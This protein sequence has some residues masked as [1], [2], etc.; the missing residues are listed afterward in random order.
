MLTQLTSTNGVSQHH[1]PP[2]GSWTVGGCGAVRKSKARQK[3][4]RNENGLVN[5]VPS[6]FL[7]AGRGRRWR[8]CYY[9]RGVCRLRAKPR[10][11]KLRGTLNLV[12]SF[13]T[14][15]K[16]SAYFQERCFLTPPCSSTWSWTGTDA[17]R[18]CC[19]K[20]QCNCA[21]VRINVADLFLGV[22]TW[23]QLADPRSNRTPNGPAKLIL[24]RVSYSHVNV[25]R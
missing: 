17:L 4:P 25:A 13:Q 2:R 8:G 10:N 16:E 24:C 19:A 21:C 22:V 14:A 20:E 6:F 1:L 7:P 3:I 5:I 18:G 15:G 11:N 12:V 23:K 9:L